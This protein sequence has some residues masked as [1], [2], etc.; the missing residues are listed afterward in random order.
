MR[1]WQRGK[2]MMQIYKNMEVAYAPEPTLYGRMK[3][4]EVEGSYAT[5]DLL[6]DSSAAVEI[7]KTSELAPASSIWTDGTA[8]A[9]LNATTIIPDKM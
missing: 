1:F 9:N 2:H 3:V 4:L 7:F 8:L 6:E 5:V